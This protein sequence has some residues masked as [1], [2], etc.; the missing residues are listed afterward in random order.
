MIYK[1]R[2]VSSELQ[3]YISQLY[4]Q[5]R[6]LDE[7]EKLTGVSKVVLLQMLNAKSTYYT[8]DEMTSF[9]TYGESILIIADTH[10]GSKK[11]NLNYI[12]EAYEM[13]IKQNVSSCIH[14]GD[15]IQGKFNQGDSTLE[16]QMDILEKR[17]PEPSEFKTNLL[18]GNHDYAVFE[19]YPYYKKLLEEKKNLNVLGYKRAYFNW[20]DYLFG[21]DHK[22]KQVNENL[23]LDDCALYFVGHGH[24]LKIKTPERLKAPTL[25]DDIINK[26]N[27][28]YPAFMIA[29]MYDD[30]YLEVDVYNF[31][32]NKA[33]IK[34]KSYFEKEL[35]DKYKVK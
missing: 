30:D 3:R 27:G 17:Y 32:N 5:G 16:Y 18:M 34:K 7:I 21:M 23:E 19:Y 9:K 6:K 20:N 12:D 10:I 25:S 22:V 33:K 28:A 11:E 35:K 31:E 2:S 24:E 1:K 4:I 13:G 8:R 14:L 29:T 15:I 26:D